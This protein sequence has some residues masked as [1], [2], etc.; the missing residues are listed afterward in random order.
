VAEPRDGTTTTTTTTTTR[1]LGRAALVVAV[2]LAWASL[3]WFLPP[4]KAWP[5]LQRASEA[6]GAMIVE[7][8]GLRRPWVWVVKSWLLAGVVV[9][10]TA[11]WHGGRRTGLLRPSAAGMRLTLLCLLVALPA[12]IALGLDPAMPAYYRAFFG[13]RGSS[14]I[15]ANALVM[16]VEHMFI[17]GAVLALALPAGLPDVDERPRRG[18]FGWRALGAAGL[19]PLVDPAAPGPRTWLGIP[20]EAW[21]AVVGQGLVF[22]CIHFTKAP[23]ELVSA[24]PGGVAVG[25]LTVRTGSVWPAATLHLGTGAVVLGTMLLAR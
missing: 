14:W 25:W 21:P 17:E 4:Q 16:V 8:S 3:F 1:L 24:F 10:A 18:F 2:A 9:A 7:A 5:A 23:S 13:D 15:A 19:G 20:V 6:I 22:G 11:R 12:Q